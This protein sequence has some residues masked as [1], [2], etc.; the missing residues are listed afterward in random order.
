MA[1]G[2]ALSGVSPYANMAPS[3]VTCASVKMKVCLLMSKNSSKVLDVKRLINASYAAW[4]SFVHVN[5]LYFLVSSRNLAACCAKFGMKSALDCIIQRKL[6]NSSFVRGG[7]MCFSA[8]TLAGS[9]R[10]PAEPI[11]R[12]QNSISVA[13]KVHLFGLRVITA[14]VMAFMTAVIAEGCLLQQ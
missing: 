11:R 7:V 5:R 3:P 4:C 12:P 8:S 6:I 13:P 1:I 2:L 10:T 9:G 14:L